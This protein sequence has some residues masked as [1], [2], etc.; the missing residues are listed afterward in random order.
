MLRTRREGELLRFGLGRD[1]RVPVT[2]PPP[3]GAADTAA[4][5]SQFRSRLHGFI[6]RRVRDPGHAEDILQEVMLR[7]HRNA[8]DLEHTPALTGW[9]F[10][11]ARNAIIDHSRRASRREFPAGLV[12][13][14]VAGAQ[15][16]GDGDEM[17]GELE[18]C[19]VPLLRSL[20]EPYAEAL[21]LTEV[22]ELTQ[23]DAARSVGISI[24]GMKSRVQRGRNELR[25]L[26]LECCDVERDRRGGIIGATPRGHGCTC[27]ARPT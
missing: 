9:I 17:R 10:T 13:A 27:S 7:I 1:L 14:D 22:Q 18:H 25:R 26:L 21:M 23:A 5:W 6:A 8:G 11:I 20:P 24:S 12:P 4:L 15:S 3:A 16:P 2:V 19:V